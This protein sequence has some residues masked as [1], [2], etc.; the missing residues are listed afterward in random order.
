MVFLL[1]C[2]DLV[3]FKGAAP[4]SELPVRPTPPA[5][6]AAPLP[7]QPAPATP[8]PRVPAPRVPAPAA[9][10][11]PPVVE[12]PAV[13]PPPSAETRPA[14][15]TEPRSDRHREELE[16]RLAEVI[17][18]RKQLSKLDAYQVLKV[19][20]TA[21]EAEIKKAYFRMARLYHPDLFGRQLDASLRVQVDEVFDAI[22][23]AYRVLTS[24]TEKGEGAKPVVPAKEEDKSKAADVRFR[25][26]K[27]LFSQA[28]YEE[29]LTYLD[30]AV[31]LNENKCDY[32]LL[33]AMAQSKIRSMTK[34]AEKNFSRAIELEP[35][36]AEGYVGLGLLYKREGLIARAKKQ[37]EKAIEVD[38]DHKAARQ[39]LITLNQE[40]EKGEGKK[41]LRGLLSK[42]LFGSKKK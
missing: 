19:P 33:L 1:Y 24:R 29:S 7:V 25:Q 9:P 11:P 16:E 35:W 28:R 22:T 38:N 5:A 13:P 2:L 14:A 27:T 4:T 8:A 42:D 17:E 12:T 15:K 31:R 6:E 41:G 10:A 21:D 20:Q 39:E 23:K 32:F 36:N 26:G 34:R 40:R 30:E 18:I 3:E 37:F